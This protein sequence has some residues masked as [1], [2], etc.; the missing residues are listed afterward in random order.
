MFKSSAFKRE[1]QEIQNRFGYDEGNHGQMSFEDYLK[2]LNTFKFILKNLNVTENGR[3]IF[4]NGTRIRVSKILFKGIEELP[5][6]SKDKTLFGDC[7]IYIKVRNVHFNLQLGYLQNII[8]T[9]GLEK[10]LDFINRETSFAKEFLKEHS[11]PRSLF[12]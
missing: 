10:T 7:M 8:S 11:L 4:P 9:F 5:Y 12:K 2:Q 3:V 1:V 6:Y